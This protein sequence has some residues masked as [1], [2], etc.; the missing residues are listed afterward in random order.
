[1]KRKRDGKPDVSCEGSGE[2]V[3]IGKLLEGVAPVDTQAGMLA[4]LASMRRQVSALQNG[5][6]E[7][8]VKTCPS[9]FTLAPAKGFRLLDTYPE[10]ATQQEELELTLYC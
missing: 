9:I 3:A 6:N 5:Q 1:M 2:D 7:E 4:A 10:Y 8:L